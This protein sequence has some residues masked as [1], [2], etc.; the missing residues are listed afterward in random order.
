MYLYNK[1]FDPIQS[2]YIGSAGTAS[3]P[4]HLHALGY[5]P[6]SLRDRSPGDAA[7]GPRDGAAAHG[8]AVP[9][10]LVPDVLREARLVQRRQPRGVEPRRVP[11]R[12]GGGGRRAP[13]RAEHLVDPRAGVPRRPGVERAA[14]RVPSRGRPAPVGGVEAALRLQPVDVREVG[15]DH[16][17]L[18][19][20]HAEGEEAEQQRLDGESH[21]REEVGGVVDAAGT[22]VP[23]VSLPDAVEKAVDHEDEGVAAGEGG[24]ED[25]QEEELGY[26]R[27]VNGKRVKSGKKRA[28][29]KWNQFHEGAGT[30][31]GKMEPISRNRAL[32]RSPCDCQSPHNC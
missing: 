29:A 11:R 26:C 1:A 9:Q 23:G 25:E 15:R 7:R 32:V 24:V 12:R 27:I 20:H 22:V 21:E 2:N 6:R 14:P 31:E 18:V 4:H 17:P 30:R 13:P 8:T 5:P 3:P 28:Q 19:D 16:V 10:Y